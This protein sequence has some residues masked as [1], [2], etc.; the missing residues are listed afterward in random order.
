M[1]FLLAT[2]EQ[3]CNSSASGN[4][5]LSQADAGGRLPPGRADQSSPEAPEGVAQ[6]T[7]WRPSTARLVT[8]P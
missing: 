1:L 3:T 2:V 6:S 8:V 7:R 5:C 4:L